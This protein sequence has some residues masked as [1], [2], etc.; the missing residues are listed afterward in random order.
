MAKPVLAAGGK[1]S[2][3]ADTIVQN[4]TLRSPLGELN[5]KA[6]TSLTLG[7]G[8]VTSNAASAKLTPF[9]RTQGGLD[10]DLPA[11][12]AESGVHGAAGEKAQPGRGKHRHRFRRDF[13]DTSG[14][15]DL[16]AFEF[17]P[18]PGGS[19][20]ILDPNDPKWLDGSLSYRPKFAVLPSLKEG[21]APWTRW[22]ARVPASRSVT[23]SICPA[24]PACRRHLCLAAG[25]L[26]LA[27]GGVPGDPGKRRRPGVPGSPALRGDGITV[28]AG[29][30]TVAGTA[31]RD[32]LWS[33]FAVETGSTINRQAEYS[34]NL[35][36]EFFAQKA[37]E[38]ETAAPM[39]PRDAGEMRFLADTSLNLNGS[40]P[41]DP[42]EQGPW[43]AA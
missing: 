4:G 38:Q 13:V 29:Y 23:A 18:G 19:V 17:V 41:G 3:E 24:A 22:K 31:I 15:G 5:L 1:L 32:P 10:W 9:G 25:P 11:G 2:L 16:F 6:A 7:A 33:G 8:S 43:R 30:R 42:C 37:A 34:R 35:A 12:F 14:G 26:R 39:L 40:D 36:N 27:A 28:V 20:D 21:F